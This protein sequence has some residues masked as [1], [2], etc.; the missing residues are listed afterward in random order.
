M[1]EGKLFSFIKQMFIEHPLNAR[2]C[3]EPGDA[4]V[5][6]AGSHEQEVRVLFPVEEGVWER[7]SL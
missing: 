7:D 6:K 2:Y 1:I 5:D 4:V 3:S